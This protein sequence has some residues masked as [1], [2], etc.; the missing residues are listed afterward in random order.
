MDFYEYLPEE[1]QQ[2][3]KGE[4]E[5][6]NAGKDLQ[7]QNDDSVDSVKKTQML[8]KFLDDQKNLKEEV[9]TSNDR[10]RRQNDTIIS[11]QTSPDI[12]RKLVTS[13]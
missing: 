10:I 7:E 13:K 2:L 5:R 8:K 9:N 12:C 1:F 3:L 6:N 4:S 11:C